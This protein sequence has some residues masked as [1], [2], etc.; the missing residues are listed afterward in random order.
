MPR[1]TNYNAP[2]DIG[3]LC[4]Q[5]DNYPSS[6]PFPSFSASTIIIDKDE[7]KIIADDYVD[8]A[9]NGSRELSPKALME[10]PNDDINTFNARLDTETNI[11]PALND[12]LATDRSQDRSLSPEIN[13]E[14]QN[15]PSPK[16]TYRNDKDTPSPKK[17]R[18]IPPTKIPRPAGS[19]VSTAESSGF[20]LGIF[21]RKNKR[22][23]WKL[24][25]MESE[26]PVDERILQEEGPPV[27]N[28]LSRRE[29]RQPGTSNRARNSRPATLL[30]P[31]F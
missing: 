2:H 12:Q 20:D 24:Q 29:Q 30:L 31:E 1:G 8:E 26:Y 18:K 28:L 9:V 13:S 7:A 19:G 25:A 14:L 11:V 16:K 17:K 10:I 15:T 23:M 3:V 27:R 6:K 4:V 21:R 5:P 22:R